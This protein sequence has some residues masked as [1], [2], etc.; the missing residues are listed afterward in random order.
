M[1]CILYMLAIIAGA[2]IGT[3]LGRLFILLVEFIIELFIFL[4]NR[5]H[6]RHIHF[7]MNKK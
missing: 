7:K 2:V 3:A 1:G 4:I 6:K 5:I